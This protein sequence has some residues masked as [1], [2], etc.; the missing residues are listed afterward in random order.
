MAQPAPQ[1]SQESQLLNLKVPPHSIEAEQSVL[2]GLLLDNSAFDRIADV[3]MEVDFYRDDHRRIF[4]HISRLVE[5]SKPA[6]VVTVD[7]S[8]KNSE[9]KDKTGGLAY[10]A[11]LAGNTPSAH[12]IRRYAEIVRECAVL[13]KLI[14][15]STDITD[16]AFNRMG[17]EVGQLLDEAESKVFQIAEAGA[18]TQQGFMQIQPL[19]TQVMERID[20]LYHKDNPSDITGVPTGYH[21]LDQ[22]TSG[23]QPGDL[24]IVAGRPS[25]GKTALALNMAE[26]VA[27]DNRLPVAVF[28]MEMS[29]TQLAMRMLGSIGHLDQH[30]LRTGKLTDDDWNRLTNAVGKLHDAPIHIDETP[31]LNALELRA[32]ARRLHRQYGTLGMIVVDYLQLMEATSSGENRATEI[33]EISR[34]LKSLAKELKVPVVALSQLNRGLEQRPNKRPVMSDLR[35]SGA[36]EQDADLILFIYRDEVYNPD[37]PDKGVSE[38]IIGKQRNGPIGTIKLTFLGEYTRFENY[39]QGGSF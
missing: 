32:R 37:T 36:I 12:N 22:R 5:R 31:A 33:S 25:M 15:V 8:V 20:L 10:L 14:E 21:D 17:K 11:E 16:S 24:I 28:S 19:L 2:G 27:V 9:D 1:T 4:R 6:D 35:E 30:K 13:R 7:E 34:S 38:I 3:V 23:L 39:A 29:G 26:H 18:R